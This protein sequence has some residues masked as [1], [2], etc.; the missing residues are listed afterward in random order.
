MSPQSS[1]F[2][3]NGE[4]CTDCNE[5]IINGLIQELELLGDV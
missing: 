4:D 2:K 1:I 5:C 3:C